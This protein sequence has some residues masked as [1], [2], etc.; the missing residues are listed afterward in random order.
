[1]S[2]NIQPSLQSKPQIPPYSLYWT[3]Y[4]EPCP[5]TTDSFFE[6]NM[7]RKALTLQYNNTHTQQKK[8][9]LYIKAVKNQ[10]RITNRYI[11]K[12]IHS[13]TCILDISS[14][15]S[16]SDVPGNKGFIL[17]NNPTIPVYNYIPVKR[18]YQ[19]GNNKYPY[20]SWKY[21]MQGFPVGKKGT[22]QASRLAAQQEL[23]NNPEKY[24]KITNYNGCFNTLCSN[25]SIELT[26]NISD[27]SINDSNS[28]N[29]LN[30]NHT[31]KPIILDPEYTDI[32]LLGQIWYYTKSPTDLSYI[33]ILTN[34]RDNWSCS[35][36]K[37]NPNNINNINNVLKTEYKTLAYLMYSSYPFIEFNLK[38][39]NENKINKYTFNVSEIFF[40]TA[41]IK[42]NRPTIKLTNSKSPNYKFFSSNYCLLNSPTK[43]Y[44]SDTSNEV[45]QNTFWWR[46]DQTGGTANLFNYFDKYKKAD[47]NTNTKLSAEIMHYY[48]V[49]TTKQTFSGNFICV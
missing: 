3:R 46:L 39:V 12:D 19:G 24:S 22:S 38:I 23:A 27:I 34:Y 35:I 32:G 4:K 6:L 49:C 8:T 13:Q 42:S 33:Y 11:Q 2:Y 47:Y 7:K 43:L 14:S 26:L 41:P 21:G 44:F 17:Y 30:L 16:Q 5:N 37:N 10:N 48:N 15:A 18:T 25:K 45:L 36:S 1:M 31:F 40:Q 29:L 20:T 9:A 28:E